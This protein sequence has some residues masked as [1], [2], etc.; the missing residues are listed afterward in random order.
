MKQISLTISF[1]TL[2]IALSLSVQAQNYKTKTT[3]PGAQKATDISKVR[4]DPS[5]N[6]ALENVIIVYKTHFDIGYSETIQQVLHDY[7]TSMADRV[8]E[9]V[10]I[11]R[12]QPKDKGITPLAR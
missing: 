2:S 4:I 7:R 1:L 3:L 5:Q 10:E 8:L 11:N 9:A 6:P 12:N